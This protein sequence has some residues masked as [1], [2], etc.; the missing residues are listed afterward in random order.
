[1]KTMRR[2]T[3]GFT[4][5]ELLVVIAIIAILAAILFPVFGAARDNARAT[6]CR[7]GMNQIGKALFMY[8]DDY[9]GRLP[10]ASRWYSAGGSTV[11]GDGTGFVGHVLRPYTGGD[12]QVWHC[13]SNPNKYNPSIP[14]SSPRNYL[15]GPALTDRGNQNFVFHY[16]HFYGTWPI[17]VGTPPQSLQLTG[18]VIGGDANF[19]PFGDSAT[20][21][22]YA[23]VGKG[24]TQVPV[25]W[26]RRIMSTAVTPQESLQGGL[27]PHRG[28]W[29]VL[30][31]DGHV[32]WQKPDDRDPW[33]TAA[34]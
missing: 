27:L 10:W 32:R 31:L 21:R 8:S 22:T 20:W 29:N 5:I 16:N 24:P 9:K 12:M 3:S 25:C 2:H 7:N 19:P 6:T 28:G 18:A 15:S 14:P 11:Y 34:P 1:M 23:A 26:E 33:T 4:L 13:P 17:P 30:F